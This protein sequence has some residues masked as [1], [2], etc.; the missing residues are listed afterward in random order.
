MTDAMNFIQNLKVGISIGN[1]LDSTKEGMDPQT[2]PAAF[3]TAWGNPVIRK[4]LVDAILDAGFNVVRIPVSW[5][6]HLGPAPDFK[7]VESWMDRVQEVVNYVYDRGAYVILNLH[8]EDWNYPYYANRDAA[9]QKMRAVWKQIAE[10]F[11]DYDN[12]LIFE[13]QNE[14]RKV[15]TELEWNGG[16]E[17]GWEVVDAT[18]AAFIDTIRSMGG[19][20]EKRYL[21][22]P[23]YAANC[24]VGIK[25]LT[26]PSSDK[27]LIVSVHAYEPYEFAL[28]IPGRE[29]WNQ[30]TKVIDELMRNL[31][32]YYI[33]KG[34]PVILG[35]FGAMN[36]NGNEAERA[37]WVKYYVKAAAKV[38]I[39]CVWWDNGLFEGEGE[40]FGLFDRNNYTVAY[41]KIVKGL[42]EG[43]L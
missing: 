3:E 33:S 43:I 23:C 32:S 22:I 21:M 30:D 17:E 19:R 36:K 11:A 24:S 15:G 12:H 39:P 9:C 29:H 28:Q 4:E 40:L 5:T 34:I 27:R 26:V 37:E 1:T 10:R 41:P 35:E 7:I 6:N 8:H 25:H 16:D 2:D 38:N 42:M 13:G 14:P 20:N 31:N 18:N